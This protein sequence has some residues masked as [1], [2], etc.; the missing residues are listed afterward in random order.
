MPDDR[1]WGDEAAKRLARLSE[2][3]APGP[4]V[5]RLP[6]TTQHREAL[7][8]LSGWMRDAG[9]DVHLDAVAVR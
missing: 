9:L 5:T 2:I 1:E 7:D 3:S 8:V 6:F 4:G